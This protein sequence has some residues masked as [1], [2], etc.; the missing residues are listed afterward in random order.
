MISKINLK[1][2]IN[3]YY[4]GNIESVVW[5]VKN[6]QLDIKFMN[7]SKD[8]IGK[9]TS[10][11][12]LPDCNL[13][14]FNTK[15]L[16]NLISICDGD[17]LLETSEKNN[18]FT[19]LKISDKNF[20]LV[21]ALADLLVIP[22]VVE[23]RTIP[24]WDLEFN[25]STEDVSNLIKAQSAMSESDVLTIK[26]SVD[27]VGVSV[28]EFMFGDEEGYNNKINYHVE[29]DIPFEVDF[30]LPFSSLLFKNIL[31]ANK[32]FDESELKISSKGLMCLKFKFG[33]TTSEYYIVRKQ[34]NNF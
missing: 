1:N 17:L 7:P 12:D 34:E 20:N 4:L 32:D 18:I 22:K 16:L 6:K 15:K 33:N 10:T 9:L 25:L 30:D 26:P 23:L 13:G 2:I 5:N 31:Y 28:C 8:V 11:I 21:Y 14:I 3:R 19:Q 24:D 29:V 27:K